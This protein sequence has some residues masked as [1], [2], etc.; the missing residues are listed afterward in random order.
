[1]KEKVLKPK[2]KLVRSVLNFLVDFFIDRPMKWNYIFTVLTEFP[3]LIYLSWEIYLEENS[4]VSKV[5]FAILLLAHSVVSIIFT[6][7]NKKDFNQRLGSFIEQ[8]YF[9][10]SQLNSERLKQFLFYGFHYLVIMICCIESYVVV[11]LNLS[12]FHFSRPLFLLLLFFLFCL[13]IVRILYISAHISPFLIIV[14]LISPFVLSS[15]IGIQ[16]GIFTWTFIAMVL[17][18]CISHLFDANIKYLLPKRS[19]TYLDD[20]KFKRRLQRKKYWLIFFSPFLYLALQFSESIISSPLFKEFIKTILNNT[21][22]TSVSYYIYETVIG[23]IIRTYSLI[24]FYIVFIANARNL[25]D[26]I[27][28]YLLNKPYPINNTLISKRKF[29]KTYNGGSQNKR[30]HRHK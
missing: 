9:E 11:T 14:F 12:V 26:R 4:H 6:I 28:R 20:E 16:N 22:E 21:D 18:I 23:S 17:A 15:L 1:M 30:S 13:I 10:Q 2:K 29:Y 3:V 24:F 5:F 8:I 19:E 27:V 7:E 25:L